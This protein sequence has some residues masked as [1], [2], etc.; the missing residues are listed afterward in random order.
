MCWEVTDPQRR[1]VFENVRW[2]QQQTQ[3][4][5]QGRPSCILSFCPLSFRSGHVLPSPFFLTLHSFSGP[6]THFR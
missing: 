1:G 4:Q 6:N 2:V 5:T 3:I